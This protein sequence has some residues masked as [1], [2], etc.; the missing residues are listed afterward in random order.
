MN[1]K[2]SFSDANK[3]DKIDENRSF[4]APQC[5]SSQAPVAIAHFYHTQLNYGAALLMLKVLLNV[6]EIPFSAL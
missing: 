3:K 1:K 6:N 5:D 2:R 4:F